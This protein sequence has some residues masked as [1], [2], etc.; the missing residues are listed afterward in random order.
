MGNRVRL[1]AATGPAGYG[2]KAC[3]EF[4]DLAFS[5]TFGPGEASQPCHC[6]DPK[7][8][9][10][11][12]VPRRALVT[13]SESGNAFGRLQGCSRLASALLGGQALVGSM[14]LREVAVQQIPHELSICT[15]DG[16]SRTTK[17]SLGC[18]HRQA[19]TEEREREG[20]LGKTDMWLS[21]ML[22]YN[23]T[24]SFCRLCVCKHAKK[25]STAHLSTPAVDSTPSGGS[26]FRSRLLSHTG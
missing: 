22:S 21:Q 25:R 16:M 2:F 5:Y 10:S 9:E 15:A 7:A 11:C 14:N 17:Q 23:T 1:G 24:S 6:S 13:L 8:P 26:F 12:R 3:F 18:F 4:F 20:R 19:Q